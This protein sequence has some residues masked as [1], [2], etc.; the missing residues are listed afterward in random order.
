[1]LS[2]IGHLLEKDW[3]KIVTTDTEQKLTGQLQQAGGAKLYKCRKRPVLRTRGL[4]LRIF[5]MGIFR[6]ITA[7]PERWSMFARALLS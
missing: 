5:S 1:M 7:N 4:E 6:Q 2:A 3:P